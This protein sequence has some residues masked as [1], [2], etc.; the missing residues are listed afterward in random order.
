M[1]TKKIEK[2]VSLLLCTLLLPFPTIFAN[3]NYNTID[4]YEHDAQ[5]NQSIIAGINEIDEILEL[6]NIE[7][8]DKGI[9][10]YEQHIADEANKIELI[11][12][13][14]E[15]L[16][17]L[18]YAYN[19]KIKLNEY[20]FEFKVISINGNS[21]LIELLTYV[22]DYEFS[23]SI[24]E[25]KGD[26][27]YE[28]ASQY[29]KSAN[30]SQYISLFTD[31]EYTF[32]FVE[33]IGE[34]KNT[35]IGNTK[36]ISDDF[37]SEN[38]S[39]SEFYNADSIIVKTYDIYEYQSYK[40]DLSI[41][42]IESNMVK[43][44][45]ALLSAGTKYEVESNN[46]YS[47]ATVT[48][49]DYDNYGKIS[50]AGD[51][52]W[53]R[54][55]F[56]SACEANF[57][58]GNIPSGC[59]YDIELYSSNG[60]SVLRTSAKSGTAD[61]LITYTV[62]ANVNYYIRVYGFNSCYSNQYYWLRAAN[63]STS[64]GNAGD[65]F[66]PN[67]TTSNA[68]I[69]GNSPN[70]ALTANIHIR[71]DVDLYRF[72]MTSAINFSVYLSN[73]PAGCDYD[74][75][76]LNSSGSVIYSSS[77]SGTNVE[78]I[79]QTLPVGTYYIK[80]F[81]Y[82]GYNAASYY[83]LTMSVYNPGGGSTGGDQYEPN[84]STGNARSININS[85]ISANIHSTTDTDFFRITVTHTMTVPLV[86]S[87]IP[88]GCDYDL[89][90]LN[91]MG[92]VIA[93]S[94]AG[95]NA[96]E[97]I[98]IS[99]TQGTYF[100]QVYA[101][102]GYNASSN[103][104]LSVAG[105]GG[106]G[107]GGDNYE[108]NNTQ[109]SATLLVNQ[110]TGVLNASIHVANDIDYYV[111]ALTSISNVTITLSNV[112]SNCRYSASI[113]NSSGTVISNVIYSGLGT[114][115]GTT[116]VNSLPVGTY[117]IVVEPNSGY[118]ATTN[119]RLDVA[120]VI[121]SSSGGDSYEPNNTISLAK[122]IS[123]SS[124][125]N[126]YIEATLHNTNDID[127]YKFTLTATRQISINLSN[128][129]AGCDYEL[130]LLNSNDIVVT[131]SV[132]GGTYPENINITLNSGT[133]YIRVRSHSGSSSTGKYKLNVYSDSDD[134]EY[135]DTL[136]TATLLGTLDENSYASHSPG[137][138]SPNSIGMDNKSIDK[139]SDVDT[140]GS[141]IALNS[142]FF[143]I[144]D[145]ISFV[146]DVDIYKFTAYSGKT[147]DVELSNI[148]GSY[149]YMF[150]ILNSSGQTVYTTPSGS[151]VS[152][153]GNYTP[154]V[155][156]TYYVRVWSN[157]GYSNN[158][159]N[160]Y[161][162]V[163]SVRDE[164]E[165][166]NTFSN[167]TSATSINR[168]T[169]NIKNDV[170]YYKFTV[171]NPSNVSID[172]TNIASGCNYTM[173]LYN[174]NYTLITTAAQSG[175]VNKNITQTL[176]ADTYYVKVY[177]N[178]TCSGQYYSLN[179]S[180]NASVDVI[181]KIF[182]IENLSSGK[183]VNI[184]FSNDDNGV[185]VNQ[186]S[187]DDTMGVQYKFVYDAYVGAYTINPLC[188]S[189]GYNRSLYKS[190]NSLILSNATPKTYWDIISVGAGQ[191]NI[192]IH[193]GTEYLTS[194]GTSITLSNQTNNNDQKWLLNEIDSFPIT[195]STNIS[196]GNIEVVLNN[197]AENKKIIPMSSASSMTIYLLYYKTHAINIEK[198]NYTRVISPTHITSSNAGQ[199]INFNL[200]PRN[201]LPSYGAPLSY[202]SSN[203]SSIFGWRNYNINSPTLDYHTG[204]DIARPLDTQVK[205]I[206]NG[207]ISINRFVDGCGNTVQVSTGTYFIT[208]M[209]LNYSDIPQTQ[210]SI[211]QNNNIGK[212]GN[213]NYLPNSPYYNPNMG[214]HLH[215]S[216]STSTSVSKGN[217][218]QYNTDFL[219]PLMFIQ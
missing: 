63:A 58:L 209:H 6:E 26:I 146:N 110:P 150:S 115:S 99:L 124:N 107:G 185:M 212:V 205:S 156:G 113:R 100:I 173:Q 13:S 198:E 91:S 40:E 162:L 121:N 216:I 85:T 60:T 201:N 182:A 138:V 38:S 126:A 61:E 10:I 44:G 90:L 210:N 48:Y 15:E 21:A 49:D 208:Y 151:A 186:C 129:P 184:H 34:T 211:N 20:P 30:N 14:E 197:L 84:E 71:S 132:M 4:G 101:Y 180:A 136:E 87:N 103:Y 65:S 199:T 139:N 119:Y 154:P 82:S 219:D 200:I 28:K 68:T 169:I 172:L 125:P 122:A 168:A 47:S 171:Q 152:K 59:D 102:S 81:S 3:D 127:Y 174:S 57:W 215:L 9:S 193:N 11:P 160:K 23:I 76:L 93:T 45:A 80:V 7:A 166:N 157:S 187:Y 52:D 144:S 142:R 36:L 94:T 214:Y 109:S 66:E 31:T 97:N 188:S 37:T 207:D 170:D 192:K 50:A 130:E 35:Y 176:N 218:N 161:S 108:P 117:Y 98:S 62:S 86:L 140:K 116:T 206:S 191:Y 153:T 56:S 32:N 179:I 78:N 18:N 83:T 16:Q 92:S 165:S 39:R 46:T 158:D 53:W 64:S 104:S 12:V 72:N 149:N 24:P 74:L 105:G 148:P 123:A 175:S 5:L 183:V 137:F 19:N 190:G 134:N 73:I 177:S 159:A 181:N 41:E 133:H 111:F 95:G 164:Y 143:S 55:S 178:G 1:K 114:N 213:T 128:I 33:I 22:N 217:S 204:V 196:N 79:D 42:S 195:I 120:T 118:S 75:Q 67:D 89:R 17:S 88:S 202:N 8:Y 106:T 70:G 54:V 131:A 155:T 135:N 203:I 2:I 96:N 147:F 194:S 167:A 69:L 25:V 112:P 29:N 141:F 43:S 189:Y 145:K 27:H 163:I 51:V 77:A